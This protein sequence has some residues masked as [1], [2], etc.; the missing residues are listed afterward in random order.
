MYS[1]YLHDERLAGNTP[2]LP[3]TTAFSV[4]KTDSIARVLSWIA[5]CYRSHGAMEDIT[6]ACHGYVSKPIGHGFK[7]G[8]HGLQLSA[9]N[10]DQS[11]VQLWG[12]VKGMAKR[13]IINACNVAQVDPFAPKEIGDGRELCRQL[14]IVT[15]TPV[16][17]PVRAQ[18]YN[19][20]ASRVKNMTF[21][22]EIDFGNWE[23]P[24][25]LFTPDGRAQN[26]TPYAGNS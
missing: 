15:G 25:F 12:R 8:G 24:V 6:I 10:V 9:D 20:Y 3:Q 16:L 4:K 7:F 17:A 14:A 22:Q 13:I 1:V 5:E 2:D 21:R 26:I 18:E 23:G 11:N 19:P